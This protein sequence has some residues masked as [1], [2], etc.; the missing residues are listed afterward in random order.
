MDSFW[1]KHPGL[2]SQLIC[3]KRIG[4][5]RQIELVLPRNVMVNKMYEEWFVTFLR[6]VTGR[7]QSIASIHVLSL[8]Q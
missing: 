5:G 4:L 8:H 1:L 6:E 7:L 2:G 3:G